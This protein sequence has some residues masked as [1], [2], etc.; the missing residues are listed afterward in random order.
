MVVVATHWPKSVGAY[1]DSAKSPLNPYND[2]FGSYVT[3]HFR[4][5]CQGH[6]DDH[7]QQVYGDAHLPGSRLLG[8]CDLVTVL[9]VYLTGRRLFGYRTALLAAALGR[10]DGPPDPVGPLLHVGFGA[11]GTAASPPST[12]TAG[13]PSDDGW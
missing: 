10:R 5:S 8:V 4:S 6:R 12:F 9:L 1:F 13:E 11:R 3:A 7:R 2:G